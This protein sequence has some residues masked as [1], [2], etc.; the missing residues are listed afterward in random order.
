MK[1]ETY[2][3]LF[4]VHRS[5]VWIFSIV[6]LLLCVSLGSCVAKEESGLG[7]LIRDD[8]NGGDP[9]HSVG[10][11]IENPHFEIQDLFG[12]V[13]A[14]M[15][16]LSKGDKV[17]PAF[18]TFERHWQRENK[19]C[20]FLDNTPISANGGDCLV[21]EHC[22]DA[23]SPACLGLGVGD[24][25][26]IAHGFL[27]V[28]EDRGF[29]PDRHPANVYTF[30]DPQ[31]VFAACPD[32]RHRT[33]VPETSGLY[34]FASDAAV[35]FRGGA[36][37]TWIFIVDD[38]HSKPTT[39]YALTS[40]SEGVQL[41]DPC[42]P[43]L[44]NTPSASCPTCAWFK[45]PAP[46]TT[47]GLQEE[48]FSCNLHITKIRVLQGTPW[49][50]PGTGRFKIIGTPVHPSSIVLFPA[51]HDGEPVFDHVDHRCYSNNSEDGDINLTS[52]RQAPNV[53]CTTPN[54][55]LNFTPHYE[56]LRPF[57]DIIWFAEFNPA[58]GGIIPTLNCGEV[59]AIEFTLERL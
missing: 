27:E 59:L 16:W 45:L 56:N 38:A 44:P 58:E 37:R 14:H 35:G 57:K 42:A 9:Y 13:P 2:K 5:R 53:D 43:S 21:C 1:D 39:S 55:V 40:Y 20:D 49:V 11:E 4:A 6:L 41:P 29:I 3:H 50:D 24:G 30:D 32:N 33:F 52:C 22:A 28:Y 36:Q 48:S 51:F 46:T 17:A 15:Y 7:A 26:G 12:P 10:F 19:M 54:C 8:P 31:K 23:A 47:A 25:T 18:D 34:R